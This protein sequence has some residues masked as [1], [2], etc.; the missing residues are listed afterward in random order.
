MSLCCD[1]DYFEPTGYPFAFIFLKLKMV[2]ACSES[3]GGEAAGLNEE[4]QGPVQ[5]GRGGHNALAHRWT[6]GA[7]YQPTQ[8]ADIA[9]RFQPR[10]IRRMLAEC[11]N[12]PPSH[13]PSHSLFLGAGWWPWGG[14]GRRVLFALCFRIIHSPKYFAPGRLCTVYHR[15]PHLALFNLH[16][17]L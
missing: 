3:R 13:L 16:L 17:C 2:P 10:A 5:R 11:P 8:P 15:H 1:I 14:S 9:T 4:C 7:G 6:S 12:V